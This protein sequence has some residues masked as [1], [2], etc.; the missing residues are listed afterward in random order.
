[1]DVEVLVSQVVHCDLVPANVLSFKAP[2]G[3]VDLDLKWPP[4]LSAQDG[5]QRRLDHSLIA[6]LVLESGIVS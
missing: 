2:T 5:V 3:S 6:R 4:R 1:M